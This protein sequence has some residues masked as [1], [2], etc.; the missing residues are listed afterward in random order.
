MKDYKFNVAPKGKLKSQFVSEK[1]IWID[2]LAIPA[3]DVPQASTT[4]SKQKNLVP[5]YN[6]GKIWRVDYL[7]TENNLTGFDLY[8]FDEYRLLR[9]LNHYEIN[10]SGEIMLTEKINIHFRK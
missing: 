7:N 4:I 2:S 8:L 9:G 6:K 1:I 10:V 3:V 5:Y